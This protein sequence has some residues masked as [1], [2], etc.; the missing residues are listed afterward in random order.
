MLHCKLLWLGVT[1]KRDLSNL[2]FF[3]KPPSWDK[4]VLV[5][6][7]PRNENE[8]CAHNALVKTAVKV[9]DKVL[10]G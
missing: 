7:A 3:P 4:L 10:E 6:I 5:T 9:R 2:S 8:I 1:L